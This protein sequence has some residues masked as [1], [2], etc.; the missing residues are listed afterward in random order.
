MLK[1]PRWELS[2]LGKGHCYEWNVC[3]FPEL[4]FCSPVTNMMVFWGRA[5]GKQLSHEGGAFM[6]GICALLRRDTG[7]FAFAFCHMRIGEDSPS[8]NQ[9][10]GSHQIPSVPAPNLE[11]SSL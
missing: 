5:F 2:Q 11:F 3:I 8:A 7:E 9:E 6:N 4:V 1:K 10:A